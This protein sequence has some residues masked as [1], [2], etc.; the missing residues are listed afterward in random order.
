[1]LLGDHRDDTGSN[2]DQGISAGYGKTFQV[3]NSWRQRFQALSA[4]FEPLHRIIVVGSPGWK[5]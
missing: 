5:A 4:R 2:R 3:F 1:M